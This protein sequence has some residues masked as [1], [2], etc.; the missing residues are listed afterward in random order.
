MDVIFFLYFYIYIQIKIKNLIIAYDIQCLF[1]TDKLTVALCWW[2]H[3][4]ER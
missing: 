2:S 1:E 4:N 3:H